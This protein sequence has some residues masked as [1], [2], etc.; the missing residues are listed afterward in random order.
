MLKSGTM[1]QLAN[2]TYFPVPE[3]L[4]ICGLVMALSA[5]FSTATRVPVAVG[6]NMT[7]TVQLVPAARVEPQVEADWEKSSEFA[8][9]NV[10]PNIVRVV[11]RL[12]FE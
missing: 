10:S 9:V 5:M 3:R 7:L 11:G 12:F 1:R 6:L 2:R 8:P 4:T